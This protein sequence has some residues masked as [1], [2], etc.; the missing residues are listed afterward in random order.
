MFRIFHNNVKIFLSEK[1][2]REFTLYVH[3]FN[4]AFRFNKIM[5]ELLDHN[6]EIIV[7]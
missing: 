7:K 6:Q 4:H 3:I 5:L 1:I 2:S